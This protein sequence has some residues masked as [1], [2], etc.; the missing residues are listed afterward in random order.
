M[1]INIVANQS[2]NPESIKSRWEQ[3]KA[4]FASF[5]DLTAPGVD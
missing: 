4:D 2:D 3:L 5:G 1:I